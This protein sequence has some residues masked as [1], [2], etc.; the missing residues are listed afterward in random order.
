MSEF[1]KLYEAKMK[2]NE[3]KVYHHDYTSAVN[4]ALDFATRN[5]YDTDPDERADII[6]VQSNRPKNGQTE[7]VTLPLYKDGKKQRKHLNFQ[8]YNMGNKSGNT[9]ELNAYVS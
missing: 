1:N 6:G 2:K 5:G 3:Y 4:S 7:R 9:Y 8:V